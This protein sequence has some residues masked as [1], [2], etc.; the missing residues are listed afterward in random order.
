MRA[1]TFGPCL[2]GYPG[3]PGTPSLPCEREK[4][5]IFIDELIILELERCNTQQLIN[6][7]LSVLLFVHSE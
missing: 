3:N 2:P 7:S 4:E 1:L 5:N 6:G